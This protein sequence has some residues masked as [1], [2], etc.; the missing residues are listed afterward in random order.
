MAKTLLRVVLFILSAGAGIAMTIF[1]K[2]L[3]HGDSQSTIIGV[4]IVATIAVFVSLYFLTKGGG[5]GGD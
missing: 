5:G 2:Q 4:G 3:R 1:W